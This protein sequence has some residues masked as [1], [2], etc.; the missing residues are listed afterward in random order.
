MYIDH[1]LPTENE[2]GLR[3]LI[4][5]QENQGIH[6]ECLTNSCKLIYKIVALFNAI[7]C[8][9]LCWQLTCRLS[10]RIINL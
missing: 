5:S 10:I 2:A 4:S 6:T 3:L 1:C 7:S 9:N 8:Q